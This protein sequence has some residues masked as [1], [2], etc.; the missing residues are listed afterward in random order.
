MKA[1][2]VIATWPNGPAEKAGICAGDEI[3]AVNGIPVPGHTWGQM[4]KEIV[5][6]SPSPIVLK[7]M[8]GKQEVEFRSERV[9][10]STLA[11]LSHQKFMR[12]RVL[13]DGFQPGLVPADET[14]QELEGLAR[15][16]DGV[17]RRVGFKFVDGMDV[18]EG[19]PE[20]QVRKLQATSFGGPEH[21]RFVGSTRIALGE[22]SYTPG[23]SAVLLKNP[24][25]VLVNLVLPNSPAQ[26]ADLF[27]GDPIL[28]VG[29]HT[30]SGLNEEQLSDL[31]LKPDE[32]REVILKLRRGQSTVSLKIETQKIRKIVEAAPYQRVGSS[33][34]RTK[35]DTPILG[36]YLLYAEKPREAMVEQID[37]PSPAFDA[38]LHIG[39]RILAVNAVAIEQITGQQLVEMLQPRGDSE[40]RLEVS[41]LDKKLEFQIKPGTYGE[42]EAKIGRKIT[43]KGPAPQHCPES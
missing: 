8:R 33:A 16:Y 12:R 9:R 30:V 24:E 34:N 39:D 6:P 29:G 4:L 25:E 18:P 35:T 31:I 10:E 3:I 5:S 40:L 20:E 41:R 19:T 27:P 21:E 2:N 32:Q 37:Y 17:N 15:F 36:C 14:R 1:I 28:E 23:F 42:V 43:K 38:G 11:Q 7:V 13:F 22:N 26:R